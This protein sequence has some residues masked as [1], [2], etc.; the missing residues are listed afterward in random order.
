MGHMCPILKKNVSCLKY[1]KMCY[2]IGTKDRII[3]DLHYANRKISKNNLMYQNE[4]IKFSYIALSQNRKTL[5]SKIDLSVCHVAILNF[6]NQ[7]G[8]LTDKHTNAHP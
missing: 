1:C 4:G 8:L 6:N 2:R 5:S 7:Q 3:V